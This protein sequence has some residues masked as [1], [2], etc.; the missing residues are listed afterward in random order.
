[1]ITK[2]KTFCLLGTYDGWS[3]IYCKI[4]MKNGEIIF[5]LRHFLQ[6]LLKV[7]CLIF[8]LDPGSFPGFGYKTKFITLHLKEQKNLSKSYQKKKIFSLLNHREMEGQKQIAQQATFKKERTFNI[9]A[10]F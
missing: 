3:K 2:V 6:K 4:Q 7:M 1:V 8:K 5:K 9:I 10:N